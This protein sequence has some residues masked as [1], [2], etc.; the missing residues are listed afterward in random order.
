MHVPYKFYLVPIADSRFALLQ[1]LKNPQTKPLR[2]LKRF[3]DAG[4]DTSLTD[5]F[6]AIAQVTNQDECGITGMGKKLLV[7][8]NSTPVLTRPQH[9]IYHFDNGSTEIVVDIHLFSYIARRGIYLLLDK[10]SKLVIDIAIVLQGESEDELPEQ[11]L[12]C[13]RLDHIDA[14]R[15]MPLPQ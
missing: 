5:R 3:L 7:S 2:L 9:R 8:H 1:S 13:C 14:N 11:I 6:K 4:N 15:A 10:T 12:G